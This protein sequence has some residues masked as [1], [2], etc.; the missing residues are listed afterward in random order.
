M[1]GDNVASARKE[2]ISDA[3]FKAIEEYLTI[4]LG[5]QG[6]VNNFSRLVNEVIPSA[7]EGI[8]NFHILTEENI[9]TKYKILVRV[10][11]NEKLIEEKLRELRIIILEGPAIK[12]LFLVS[13]KNRK[14]RG[15][16]SFWWKDPEKNNQLTSTELILHRV[17]QERGFNPV[18]RISSMPEGY[19]PPEM[20]QEV[21]AEEEAIKWGKLFSADVIV[22]GNSEIIQNE[23]VTVSL[24]AI[25]VMKENV[26]AQG[27]SG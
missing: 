25:D 13:P 20:R 5:S 10:K 26:I 17:F 27:F 24:K 22:I 23:N 8:E 1:T 6:M 19:Y 9:G 3:M 4:S 18:N 11:V 12:L 14:R 16:V 2:A 15:E 21:L 7:G